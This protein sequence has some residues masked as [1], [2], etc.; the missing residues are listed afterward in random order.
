MGQLFSQLQKPAEEAHGEALAIEEPKFEEPTIAEP[1]SPSFT[2]FRKLPPEM[3]DRIWK[4]SL[5]GTYRQKQDLHSNF[6]NCIDL[7]PRQVY[8]CGI[9]LKLGM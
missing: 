6:P 5:P 8:S 2:L 4:F 1:P 3:R 9:E 7:L